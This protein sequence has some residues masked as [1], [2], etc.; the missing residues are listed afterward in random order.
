MD[1][2]LQWGWANQRG[3]RR[4]SAVSL[5]SIFE[6]GVCVVGG[7]DNLG[8]NGEHFSLPSPAAGQAL[9]VA[10]GDNEWLGSLNDIG[11]WNVPLTNGTVIGQ[12][13]R[14]TS[15]GEVSALYNTPMYNN[16]TGPLSQYGVKAMDQ[17]FT[18]YDAANPTNVGL[19]TTSNG[20]L[21]WRYV[22]SGLTL[23]SG[24]AGQPVSG[25][26]AVQLD[27]DGGGVETVLPGDA[28][29][30]GKVDINDLTS[31]SRTTARPG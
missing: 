30:D 12:T 1:N 13:C 29:L 2:G 19:V 28:N 9:E 18:L 26:Y 16:H 24:A 23:G 20:T 7:S 25:Q 21:A 6:N 4:L 8:W 10:G 14:G 22:A 3:Q 11:M 27:S 31:C 5:C 17:L 15:G